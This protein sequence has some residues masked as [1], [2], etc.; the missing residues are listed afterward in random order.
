MNVAAGNSVLGLKK[1][2]KGVYYVV[3]Q[4]GSHKQIIKVVVK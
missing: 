4:S 3:V 1:Q 2:K